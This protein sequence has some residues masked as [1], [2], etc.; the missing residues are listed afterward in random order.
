[1][2]R[3][4]SLLLIKQQFSA[5]K[6]QSE[7]MH[8]LAITDSLTHVYNR[9]YLVD[10]GDQFLAQRSNHPV[11]ALILDIDHFKKVNDNLGHITGDK[12]LKAL[13]ALLLER[14]P[15]NAMVVRFGGEEF[16]LLVPRCSH[17]DA[18]KCAESLRCEIETLKPAEV[19]VTVSVGLASNQQNPDISLTQLLNQADKALYAAKAQGRNK[20]CA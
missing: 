11:A 3:I 12:V 5:L 20:V 4:R 19:S 17:T 15:E 9:R 1:M 2:A 14:L 8:R 6:R 18:H 13:G 10:H 16:V 7:A